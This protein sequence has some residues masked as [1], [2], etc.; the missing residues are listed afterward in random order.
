MTV[1]ALATGSLLRTPEQRTS[2]NDRSYVTTTLLIKDGDGSKFVRIVAFSESVQSDL[3]RLS[4]GDA[5]SAQGPLKA[6]TYAARDGTA[7]VSLSIVASN[8]LA[9]RQ[10]PKEKQKAAAPQ[11]TLSRQQRVAGSWTA[12]SGDPNDE[13]DFGGGPPP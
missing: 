13:I 1:H 11:D 5:L 12:A 6:E 2:K 4:A 7:K 10:P 3:M 8:V 9:L